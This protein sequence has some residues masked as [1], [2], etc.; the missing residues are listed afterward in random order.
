[1]KPN[2]AFFPLLVLV[3]TL[4][5]PVSLMAVYSIIGLILSFFGVELPR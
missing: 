1:M 2:E 4:A 5:V 3:M